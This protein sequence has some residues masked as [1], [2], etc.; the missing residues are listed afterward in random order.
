MVEF[1]HLDSPREGCAVC[2]LDLVVDSDDWR[3]GVAI[4][5]KEFKRM[6]EFGMSENELQ[7]CLSA[8]LSDSE[9]LAAQ[10]DRMTNQDQL[11]Y[12]MESVACEHTFMDAM[13]THAATQIV[14]AALSVEDVNKVAKEVCR[15]IAY[16]G[17]EGED[18]PSSIV[19]CA[20]T[21]V[22]VS[23]E[24]VMEALESAASQVR[25]LPTQL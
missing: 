6:A 5:V 21:G 3:N 7:R 4:A 17:Q 25:S 13:Q 19:A 8:L 20:P 12:L 18:M 9:Q 10:G 24:A 2:A 11:T 1:S 16:F 23:K 22:E 14:T 15:H